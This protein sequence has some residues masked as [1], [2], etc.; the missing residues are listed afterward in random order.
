M[1][2]R[3]KHVINRIIELPTYT[4]NSPWG[5]FLSHLAGISPLGMLAHSGD[6]TNTTQPSKYGGFHTWG[7]PQDEW[8]IIYHG[9]SHENMDDEQGYSYFRK[10]PYMKP[11]KLKKVQKCGWIL[12]CLPYE[13][14]IFCHVAHIDPRFGVPKGKRMETSTVPPGFADLE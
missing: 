5:F 6:T 7:S 13:M 11:S 12:L 4:T 1:I 9:K 10:A 3:K 8:F 14:A 2:Y